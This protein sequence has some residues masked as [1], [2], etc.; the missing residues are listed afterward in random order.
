MKRYNVSDQLNF[1]SK[2]VAERL[3]EHGDCSQSDVLLSIIFAR[4]AESAWKRFLRNPSGFRCQH[5]PEMEPNPN[6]IGD[7]T[8]Y[9]GKLRLIRVK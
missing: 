1:I 7:L 5:Y 2:T 3:Q 9:D 6:F 8:E 4:R